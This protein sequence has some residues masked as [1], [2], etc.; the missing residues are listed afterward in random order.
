MN[1]FFSICTVLLVVSL[2]AKIA[3]VFGYVKQNNMI[4]ECPEADNLGMV[5]S[6]FEN[7]GTLLG[8]LAALVVFD[9]IVVL[10]ML[11]VTVLF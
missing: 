5:F 6:V 11:V 8:G 9:E 4:E 1:M 3:I 10:I 2:V 7:I